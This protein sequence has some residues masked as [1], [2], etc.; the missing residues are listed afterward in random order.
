M[1]ALV[2]PFANGAVD[3]PRLRALIEF[4]IEAGTCAV[5]V[6]GTTGEAATLSF[7]EKSLVMKTAVA[8]ANQRIPV[9]AGTAAN[10]TRDCITLTQLAMS[11]GVD[12]ALIMTPAYIK[13]TQEGLYEH[14]SAI[15]HDVAIP[16]ILYNVTQRTACDLLPETVLRLSHV[17]NIIGIK[18]ANSDISRFHALKDACA[19]RM[20][21]YSGDDATVAARSVFAGSDM[22]MVSELFLN[23]LPELV[24]SGKVS[25][26]TVDLAC[27]RILETKYRLGLFQDPYRSLN[28]KAPAQYHLSNEHRNVAYQAA[29][30]SFVLLQNGQRALTKPVERAAFETK[31]SANLLPL[32]VNTKVA[33]IGP[34][35][36]D[37]RNLI[38]NWSGAGDHQ[39]A[40]SLWEALHKG[41][42]WDGQVLQGDVNV[43][44]GLPK[45]NIDNRNLAGEGDNQYAL[46]CN[47]LE[48]P[49][50]IARLNEHGGMIEKSEKS[51]DVLI[52]EAVELAMRSDVAVLYLGETFGMSGEAASRSN[53]QLPEN[54]KKLLRAVAATGKPIV[55]L[56]MTGRPLDLSEE[57]GLATSIMVTWFPG[58]QAGMAVRDVLYG[59]KSPSGKLTMTFPRSVGQVP[60]YYNAKNTGR[61]FDEKQKY[62]SKYLDIQNSPLFAFGHGLSYGSTA[63]GFGG[64]SLSSDTFVLDANATNAQV[65]FDVVV[66]HTGGQSHSETI[67]LYTHQRS[68]TL[69]RP[70]KELKRFIKIALTTEDS[71]YATKIKAVTFTLSAKDFSYFDESGK[72]I[73]EAGLYDVWIGTASDQLPLHKVVKVVK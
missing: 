71:V 31:T 58:T 15:A 55:L 54:Q 6:A 35:I 34:F 49:A 51:T 13:P 65:E 21:I 70:L 11:C 16:I 22:D 37:K 63:L 61:P 59:E 68:A 23:K 28:D 64:N 47:M 57:V 29:V 73:L 26:S 56:L 48:D 3:L 27:R 17:P 42:K 14:Y 2:T 5:V 44:D 1:V 36:K 30:E 53:I 38:G 66:F 39:K 32:N 20:D 7:D 8:A 25:E 43:Y 50:L 69:T 19:E 67:Q 40:I 10:A 52:Q 9:I 60:I 41:A 72:P 24:K 45:V 12:A 18:E 33:W 4:H 62:T 46:G